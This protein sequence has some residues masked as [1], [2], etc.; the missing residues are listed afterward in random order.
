MQILQNVWTALTT[1]NDLILGIISIP[2]AFLEAFFTTL[3]FTTFFNLKTS[4]YKIIFFNFN[5][6]YTRLFK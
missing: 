4:K 2:F 3:L 5:I 6:F 1:E